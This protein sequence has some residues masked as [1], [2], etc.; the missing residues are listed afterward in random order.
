MVDITEYGN[1]WVGYSPMGPPLP[2]ELRPEPVATYRALLPGNVHSSITLNVVGDRTDMIATLNRSP[3]Y[4][5]FAS[6]DHD[7]FQAAPDRV[8]DGHRFRT[9]P[10]RRLN[11]DGGP[12]YR[13]DSTRPTSA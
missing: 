1:G 10:V 6:P 5:P 2:R 7:G 11:A 12:T 4:M 13:T 3:E 9:Q 8:P